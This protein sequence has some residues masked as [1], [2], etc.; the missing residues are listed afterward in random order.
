MRET[1][2]ESHH[3]VHWK[4]L[5]TVLKEHEAVSELCQVLGLLV[6]TA[7]F[8]GEDL[9]IKLRGSFHLQFR[10]GDFGFFQMAGETRRVALGNPDLQF[11]SQ[12]PQPPQNGGG[13][14]PD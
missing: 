8:V 9:C 13:S 14:G 1:W 12:C 10:A 2:S 6:E 7:V 11:E 5:C 4:W 3:Q